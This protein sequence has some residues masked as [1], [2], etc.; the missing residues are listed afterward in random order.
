MARCIGADQ[1]AVVTIFGNLRHG[2]VVPQTR[3]HEGYDAA[4]GFERQAGKFVEAHFFQNRDAGFWLGQ[5]QFF[6]LFLH[7]GP[8]FVNGQYPGD[9]VE[10]IRLSIQRWCADPLPQGFLLSLLERLAYFVPGRHLDEHL[11]FWVFGFAFADL[12]F[13]GVGQPTKA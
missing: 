11:L 7:F 4:Q 6:Q 8:I 13:A 12:G 3:F 10:P 9:L 1:L 2:L 5:G